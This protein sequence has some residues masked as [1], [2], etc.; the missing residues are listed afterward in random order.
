MEDK[1]DVIVVGA[2]IAGC[3]VSTLYAR[4][5]YKVLL[6]D[7]KTE[8]TAYK[9]KCTH[10]IQP[11]A[12]P[13][14]QAMGLEDRFREIGAL[15]NNPAIWSEHGWV[16]PDVNRERG[17]P[18]YGFN[19]TRK[20]LD[21][22]LRDVA[23]EAGVDFRL[24]YAVRDLIRDAEGK[25]SGVKV[26]TPEGAS[27][28]VQASLTIGAD[29]RNSGIA[30]LMGTRQTEYPNERFALFSYYKGVTLTSG[31]N[32]QFWF[33]GDRSLFA[34]PLHDDT[35]LLC[36]FLPQA[37][38]DAWQGE[39]AGQRLVDAFSRL[40]GAP[41]MTAIERI[42]DVHKMMDMTN[43][44]RYPAGHGVAL[45][46]DAALQSDPMSGIG[47][48]WAIQSAK[49]LFDETRLY[50][51][52]PVMQRVSL[53]RYAKHHRKQLLP[54]NKFIVQS[55]LAKPHGFLEKMVFKAAAK[56]QEVA[57]LLGD[58]VGRTIPV[59]EFLKPTNVIKY[60]G[61]SLGKS[62]SGATA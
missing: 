16:T 50:V 47:C 44:Y 17:A 11:S 43:C 21:P 45:I 53:I 25:V 32:S 1:Y 30:R 39:D 34:Y 26:T 29:G 3:I 24:G 54:H 19:I 7:K 59:S 55:S 27:T 36:A 33:F 62:D 58:F 37:E 49:W 56:N 52:H 38:R 35:V 31:E 61:S 18:T 28:T 60:I 57:D 48:G 46:G 23:E 4:E 10:Y 41:D 13:V 15:P 12:T 20:K 42:D 40:P 14:I 2:G 51:K 6:L 8:R 5:G 22:M 9:R